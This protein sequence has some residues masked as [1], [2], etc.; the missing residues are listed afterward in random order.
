M[1]IARINMLE[2]INYGGGGIRLRY[3]R[4]SLGISG[5]TL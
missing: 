2:S 5:I 4:Y 1:K 3:P